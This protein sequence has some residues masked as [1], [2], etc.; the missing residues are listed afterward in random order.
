MSLRDVVASIPAIAGRIVAPLLCDVK[1]EAWISDDG[2]GGSVFGNTDP[3]EGTPA[4]TPGAF[5]TWPG[6]VEWKSVT[7]GTIQGPTA[8]SRTVITF[9]E[10]HEIDLRDRFTLPDG[11]TGPILDLGG[12]QG[13]LV[14]PQTGRAYAPMVMLG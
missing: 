7:V 13:S 2:L 14:D 10:P 1:H 4:G 12:P 3:Q 11:D 6:L 5:D 9:L 8:V